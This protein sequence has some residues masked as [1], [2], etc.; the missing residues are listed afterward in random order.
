MMRDVWTEFARKFEDLWVNNNKGELPPP[1]YWDFPGG[2]EAFAEFRRRYIHN[3]L[4]DATGHGGSKML[5]RMMG[6]VSVWDITVIQDL[7]KRAVA[8]RAGI[9]IG[10]RWVLERDSINSEEDLAGIVLE[11]I[12]G[13]EV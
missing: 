4:R 7:E 3:I 9:R 6:I 12:R 8:E 11:E 10:S 2:E 1:K 5:R 13:V